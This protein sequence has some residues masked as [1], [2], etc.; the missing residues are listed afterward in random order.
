MKER[1]LRSA[2]VYYPNIRDD[3]DGLAKKLAS[4]GKKWISD[5]DVEEARG[6]VLRFILQFDEMWIE[7]GH[8]D[9][10]ET[11]RVEEGFRNYS[12]T[13]LNVFKEYEGLMANRMRTGNQDGDWY[14]MQDELA[15]YIYEW[16]LERS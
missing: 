13:T 7:T 11:R 2:L 9:V 3:V 14:K 10:L 4:Y 15:T 8:S 16:A 5:D 6:R 12:H 1:R